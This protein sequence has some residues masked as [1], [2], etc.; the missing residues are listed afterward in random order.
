[1]SIIQL[2]CVEMESPAKPVSQVAE[3][4]IVDV[5]LSEN[6]NKSSKSESED[7]TAKATTLSSEESVDSKPDDKNED[8]SENIA[9]KLEQLDIDNAPEK[10]LTHKEK[11]KLKKEA[12]T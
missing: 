11:K 12:S 8:I 5:E 2:Y 9:E 4:P 3:K 10:K 7:V 6:K 1:M